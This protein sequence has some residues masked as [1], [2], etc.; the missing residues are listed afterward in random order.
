M[1]FKISRRL[2]QILHTGNESLHEIRACLLNIT[3]KETFLEADISS[4]RV[5]LLIHHC[6]ILIGVFQ[7]E[8]EKSETLKKEIARLL[9]S[10]ITFDPFIDLKFDSSEKSLTLQ[11]MIL[12]QEVF[13]TEGNHILH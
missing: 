3:G 9:D 2:L 1:K 7:N 5:N 11:Y 13:N 10:L 4:I 12:A 6:L 8:K